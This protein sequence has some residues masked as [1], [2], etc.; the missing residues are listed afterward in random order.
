MSLE[1]IRS[2]YDRAFEYMQLKVI[3]KIQAFCRRLIMMKQYQEH[4]KRQKLQD[5]VRPRKY[6]TQEENR[7]TLDSN[8]RFTAEDIM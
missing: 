6:F 3:V 8:S 7:E 1:E 2:K 5:E 4:I